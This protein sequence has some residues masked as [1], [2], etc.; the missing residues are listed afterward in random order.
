MSRR[1]PGDA[2]DQ[3]LDEQ[4]DVSKFT[5]KFD[6]TEFVGSVSE[7]L[8]AQSKENSGPFDPKP[9]IRSFEATVDQL[10]SIRKDVQAKTE[11]M[12]KSV[13]V[14]EREY[15]KKMDGLNRGFE[16]AP[17]SQAWRAA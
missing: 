8:I 6:V 2:G 10:I 15:S 17:R 4:L 14:S 9:F 1:R 3:S 12:E 5:G 11:Q 7:K 16:S 13:R